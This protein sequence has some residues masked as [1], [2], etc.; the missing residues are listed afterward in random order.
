ML[1]KRCALVCSLC[2]WVLLTPHISRPATAAGVAIDPTTQPLL[3]FSDLSY[4]GGFRLPAGMANG[5]AFDFGGRTIGYNPAANSLFVASRRSQVAEVSIPTPVDSN[6]VTDMPFA[7]YLQPFVD[8]TEAN[9]GQ[10]S[11]NDAAIDG[12]LVANGRLYGSVFIYYDAQNV[13]RVSHYSRSLT[14]SEPS[15]RGMYSVGDPAKTGFVSGYMATVPPEW[16][17]LL[18]GPAVT[19]QCCIPIVTRTSFGPAAFAWNPADLGT[20]PMT[21]T[22]LL[23]YTGDHATLGSWGG[24]DPTYG[25][26]TAMGGLALIAGTRTALFVGRNGT[27]PFCYGNGTPD[28]ALV[29]VHAGDGEIYCYDP[30]SSDK[31]QHAYPYNYQIWAYDLNDFAAVKAG[32]KQPWEVVPYGVWPLTFPTPE[33]AVQIGGVAYDAARQLLYVTQMMADRDGYGYRPV[34]HALKITV[35]GSTGGGTPVGAPAQVTTPLAGST[36]RAS[37]AQFQWTAGTSVS[38]YQLSVGAATGGTELFNQNVGSS[39]GATVSG[40]PTNGSTLY[41]RLASLINGSW[42]NRYS[43]YAAF[44]ATIVTQMVAP[45]SG[46]TLTA[47]TAQFQWT[48]GTGVSEYWLEVGSMANPQQ[49]YSQGLAS[50]NATVSSLPTD[51]S[52][53]SARLWSK[54]NGSW[55]STSYMYTAST[56]ISARAQMTAPALSSTLTS[57][58]VTFQWTGGTG[59][60]QYWLTVGSTAGAQDFYSEGL[61]SLSTIV[62][63]LPSDGSTVYARMW[64]K[65]PAGW[66]Y[67]DYTYTALFS[68]PARA[69]MIAPAP[70]ST[71]T[72]ST[73]TFQWTGGT[74]VSQYWLTVGS[75]AGAQDFYSQGLTGL[76]TTASAL[77]TDGRTVYARLWSRLDGGWLYNDYVYI[78]R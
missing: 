50:S 77:P 32:Q 64:S 23:Y 22:S 18:G 56:I 20:T 25:G 29:G 1:L 47:S 49:Y 54:V 51:G 41:V 13:Q 52:V 57:S 73:V 66:Q 46:S 38:Q 53:V 43:T 24:S 11:N 3:Q 76:S 7:Q 39:L 58:T 67:N 62:S 33:A 12:L 6:L 35:P 16:Q 69:Q 72:S 78:A 15:F 28:L 59:A 75:T 4:V 44:T 30:T 74:G 71:L 61:T 14:L 17:T 10:I 19:G 31:G 48:A 63:T 65:L 60:S 37:T 34:I 9:L 55:Q 42:Q 45:A 68:A 21:A 8:P 70:S 36:L 40:L 26:T 5:E 2:V 27:G